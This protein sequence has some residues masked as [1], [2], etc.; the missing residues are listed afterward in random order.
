[1]G[2]RET[3]LRPES[4]ATFIDFEGNAIRLTAERQVHILEHSEMHDQLIGL[5]RL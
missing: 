1:V 2:D 4:A 5:P 3:S